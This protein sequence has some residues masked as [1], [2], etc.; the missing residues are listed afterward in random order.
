[1]CAGFGWD[2]DGDLLA[3]ISL[4]APYIILWDSNTGKKQQLDTGLRDPLTCV[5]WAK[6]S[7]LLAVGTARGNVAIYNHNTANEVSTKK[8]WK[9][10][11]NMRSWRKPTDHRHRPASRSDPAGIEPGLRKWEIQEYIYIF[12]PPLCTA[13][14]RGNVR[15]CDVTAPFHSACRLSAAPGA[16]YFS[17]SVVLRFTKAGKYMH[18]VPTVVVIQPVRVKSVSSKGYIST[19]FQTTANHQ[20][21]SPNKVALCKRK[22]FSPAGEGQY[23]SPGFSVK[24]LAYSLMDLGT[25]LIVDFE[26][27]QKEMV[28]GELESAA[29]EIIMEKKRSHDVVVVRLL[30]SHLGSK[31]GSIPGRVSSRFLHVGIILNNA[32]CQWVFSGISHFSRP[33]IPE[34]LH[35]RLT[36]PTS[37]LKTSLLWAAQIS[38]LFT[39]MSESSET[40]EMEI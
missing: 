31:L 32:A 23:D 24:Y 3:V 18:V 30:A 17:L 15:S 36:S 19:D 20:K 22:N 12:C 13:A 21:G 37:A 29:C 27:V 11:G 8:R 34:L 2:A 38:S 7:P 26:L 10:K 25:S 35:T 16:C 5:M 39:H 9:S 40:C 33:F 1:M 28:K 6:T 14:T 4:N